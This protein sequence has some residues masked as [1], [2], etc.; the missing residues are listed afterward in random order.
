MAERIWYLKRCSLFQPVDAAQIAQLEPQC[1]IRTF[2]RGS[3]VYAPR[4]AADGLLLLASGRV[5]IYTITDDGKEAILAL[6][7]PGEVFGELAV[8]DGGA[9]EDYAEACE[10]ADVVFIPVDAAK[11]LMD[12]NHRVSL[13]ITKLIGLRRRRLERRLKNLLF[14]STRQ[15]VVHALLDLAEQYGR[16]SPE[17]VKLQVRLSHQELANLIGA[18]R[19]SVTLVL[20]ELQ[21]E[22]C[23][24]VARRRIVLTDVA[25]LA[26]GVNVPAPAVAN[27]PNCVPPNRTGRRG[28]K[29][30]G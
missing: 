23:L 16:V 24:R 19:E 7:E 2:S 12:A 13:A 10:K 30:Y 21:L 20:G 8:I 9:R 28:A 25:A 18:T 15:R 27:Q 11:E 4:D 14:R 22:K 29:E 3:L 6:I 5:K 1:R 17:G 26:A